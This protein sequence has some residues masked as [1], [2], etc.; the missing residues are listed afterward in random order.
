MSR[1]RAAQIK[2]AR[3][4]LGWKPHPEPHIEAQLDAMAARVVDAI[5]AVPDGTRGQCPVCGENF[6]LTKAG[7]MR[8][9]NGDVYVGG[10]RQV[11]EGVGKPPVGE[12]SDVD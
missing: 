10:W 2:A 9:H 5:V 4:A 3:G 11:C 12:V 8:H 6:A 7:V 1:L